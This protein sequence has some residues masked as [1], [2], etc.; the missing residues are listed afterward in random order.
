MNACA[1]K[2]LCNIPDVDFYY[3]AHQLSEEAMRQIDT[4]R[5]LFVAAMQNGDWSFIQYQSPRTTSNNFTL[6]KAIVVRLGG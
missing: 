2:G 1:Q 6:G 3:R 5:P 4:L